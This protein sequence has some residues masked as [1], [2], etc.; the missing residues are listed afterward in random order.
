MHKMK[1][2]Q[3]TILRTKEMAT[4]AQTLS[5]T[6]TEG[7]NVQLWYIEDHDY[8]TVMAPLLAVGYYTVDTLNAALK[9]QAD[10]FN[11]NLK[12]CTGVE[13]FWDTVK[14]LYER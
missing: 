10:L 6:T 13:N 14:D 1:F 8:S 3:A 2:G 4:M 11:L 9:R 12:R 5:Q 7:K